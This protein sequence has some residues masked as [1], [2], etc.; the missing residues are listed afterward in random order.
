MSAYKE[1][2]YSVGIV[3]LFSLLGVLFAHLLFEL[4]DYISLVFSV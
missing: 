1:I 3:C 4:M 2:I